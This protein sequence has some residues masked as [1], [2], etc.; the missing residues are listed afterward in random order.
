MGYSVQVSKLI[1]GNWK[2]WYSV[3]SGSCASMASSN[4]QTGCTVTGALVGTTYKFRVITS[5]AA[6]NSE[7]SNE[8]NPLVALQ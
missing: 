4:E 6:G 1:S 2:A 3:V 5:T 8:T 7:P